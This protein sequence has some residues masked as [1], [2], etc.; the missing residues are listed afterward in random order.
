MV[1]HG[2]CPYCGE[3]YRSRPWRDADFIQC[4]SCGLLRPRQL[5]GA[6]DAQRMLEAR[7]AK[8]FPTK[9][10]LDC[11]GS[12][13]YGGPSPEMA[14]ML[15][16]YCRD[17]LAGGRALDIGAGLGDF[18]SCLSHLGM[19]ASGIEPFAR[20]AAI[21]RQY[22]LD[23]RYGKFDAA[24]MNTQF[25]GEKFHLISS[26]ESLYYLNIRETIDLVRCRLA[27][28]GVFYIKSHLA[29]SPY[30][31]RGAKIV[32]GMG[33]WVQCFYTSST[34]IN[35]LRRER[36]NVFAVQYVPF[37]VPQAINGWA[38]PAWLAERLQILFKFLPAARVHI[39]S[40]KT[41][42]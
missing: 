12:E 11:Q 24:T 17:L 25:G 15:Q 36:F 10:I 2:A 38:M 23:I 37:S 1:E 27:P 13:V 28:D 9:P 42:N 3:I 7:Y 16:T 26:V 4:I 19:R 21:G 5:V 33:E 40:R 35:I 39:L 8:S 18:V 14:R 20:S 30:F 34:L 6:N 41:G 29:E 32:D 22:D 31:W